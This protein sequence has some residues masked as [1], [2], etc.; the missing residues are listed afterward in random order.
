MTLW[1]GYVR[2][3]AT[4]HGHDLVLVHAHA[5]RWRMVG[6]SLSV[7]NLRSCAGGGA[8]RVLRRGEKTAATVYTVALGARG[9]KTR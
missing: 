5:Q 7:R 8:M 2:L 6:F 9:T 1:H 3:P 4:A